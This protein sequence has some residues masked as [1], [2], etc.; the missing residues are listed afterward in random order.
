MSPFAGFRAIARDPVLRFVTAALISTGAVPAAIAPYQSL[1]AIT[2][3]GF[4]PLGYA[5]VLIVAALT[6]VSGA[7]AAGILADQYACRRR[8]ALTLVTLMVTAM[9]LVR[10][11]PSPASFA[12]T[13]ALLLPASAGLFGQLFALARIVTASHPRAERDRLGTLIRAAYSLPYVSVLVLLSLAIGAGMPLIDVYSVSLVAALISLALVLRLWPEDASLPENRRSGLSFRAALAEIAHPAVVVRLIA[14]GLSGSGAALYMVLLGPM[15]TS[16]GRLDGIVALFAGCVA[17]L[18]IPAMM[19][20]S[21]LV[22]RWSKARIIFLG[23]AVHSGFLVCFAASAHIGP[24]LLLTLP[25]GFG[26]G[27]LLTMPLGYVQDLMHHRPG[28]GGALIAVNQFL[29]SAFAALAFV[30]GTRAEGYAAAALTGALFAL[31][32]AG[33]LLA[34]DRRPAPATP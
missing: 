7:I 20:A 28:A 18:E 9:A 29:V 17:G 16:Q 30:I 26:A 34:L 2:R 12:L 33:L 5:A 23:A 19:I 14:L 15:M 21:S 1:L 3:F 11:A 32:G 24:V 10:L 4:S 27:L 8:I 22:G 31:T 13:H 6:A 25:A